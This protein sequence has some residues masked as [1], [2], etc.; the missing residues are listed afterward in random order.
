MGYLYDDMI[1]FGNLGSNVAITTLWTKKEQIVEAM[2][3]SKIAI[4]G[5]LY[6]KTQGINAVIRNLLMNKNIRYLFVTGEDISGSGQALI[7]LFQKGIDEDRRIMGSASRIDKEIDLDSFED[8]RKNVR[9]FDRRSSS[10]ST[11]A[12][13]IDSLESLPSYGGPEQFPL[14]EPEAP[15]RLPSE[16]SAFSVSSSSIGDAWLDILKTIMNFGDL[17]K[18]QFHD[19]Q[20]EVLN[21]VAVIHGEDPDDPDWKP[22]YEFTREELNGYIP[23]VITKKSIE[24]VEYTYGQRLRDHDGIDQVKGIID[25][26]KGCRF[27]RRAVAFTWDVSKDHDSSKSPCLD[28]I[29]AVVQDDKLHLTAY[30]R[31]NDMYGAWP[32]NAYALRKLQKIMAEGVGISMGALTTISCS[33]H[34]YSSQWNKVKDILD[35]YGVPSASFDPR[36]NF[37]ITLEDGKLHLRHLDHEGTVIGEIDGDASEILDWLEREKRVSDVSHALYLGRELQKAESAL[38][39]GRRYVQDR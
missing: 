29:Q 34:I 18:S 38:K 37:S 28:L 1:E 7:D 25:K 4:V 2:D 9:V 14:A 3:M 23:Q 33:A 36:G 13:E 39:E 21:M 35:E 17:K 27:T 19:D 26:I 32:R 5:Q 11:I 8:M 15:S 20:K 22:F 6:S 31:S 16:T 30:F 12:E 10:Y 24:G